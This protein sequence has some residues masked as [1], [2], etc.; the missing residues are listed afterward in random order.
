LIYNEHIKC[1]FEVFSNGILYY[2][3]EGDE[4]SIDYQGVTASQH[5]TTSETPSPSTSQ[6]TVKETLCQ[7]FQFLPPYPDLSSL[8]TANAH[9]LRESD[10]GVQLIT[11][12]EAKI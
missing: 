8:P 11:S 9:I 1:Y 10:N 7:S 4:S 5:P 2:N 3:I 12:Q 6:T